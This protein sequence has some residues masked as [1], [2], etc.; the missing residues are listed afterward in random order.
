MD[1]DSFYPAFVTAAKILGLGEVIVKKITTNGVKLLEEKI[2][3]EKPPYTNVNQ[4]QWFSEK[5]KRISSYIAAFEFVHKVLGEETLLHELEL[6][7]IGGWGNT[8]LNL[9]ST[10]IEPESP[11]LMPEIGISVVDRITKAGNFRTLLDA[12]RRSSFLQLLSP[13]KTKLA[14]G[15]VTGAGVKVVGSKGWNVVKNGANEYEITFT[16][17]EYPLGTLAIGADA[18]NTRRTFSGA[19]ASPTK[20]I[21]SMTAGIGAPEAIKFCFLVLG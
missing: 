15:V 12:E 18:Q 19:F 7:V 9:S 16:E 1:S 6:G 8:Q 5:L 11:E 4:V 3:S 13:E 20:L 10:D 21:V 2:S 14:W 17:T